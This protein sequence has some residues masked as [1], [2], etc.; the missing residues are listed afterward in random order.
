VAKVEEHLLS[1]HKALSS[2]PKIIKKKREGG[3]WGREMEDSRQGR[4]VC[5]KKEPW[6]YGWLVPVARPKCSWALEVSL[7]MVSESPQG[8]R[9]DF[10][11]KGLPGNRAAAGY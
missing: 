6:N 3:G 5:N 9:Q 2:N 4:G 7:S 1:K 8:K 10:I 11:G